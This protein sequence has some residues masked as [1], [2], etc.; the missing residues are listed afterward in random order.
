MAVRAV[1]IDEDLI[2]RCVAGETQA[3]CELYRAYHGL[4]VRLLNRLGLPPGE[5]EDVSQEVFVR[6]FRGLGRFE[7]R[8]DF[9]TWVYRIAVNQARRH[10]RS[11]VPRFLSCVVPGP[12]D[13]APVVGPES[14]WPASAR[15]V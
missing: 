11:R 1:A 8:A 14:S 5:I 10:R 2:D 15:V 13:G 4:V 3:W 6:V 7:R 9:G 12:P